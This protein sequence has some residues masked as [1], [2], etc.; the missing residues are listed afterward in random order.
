MTSSGRYPNQRIPISIRG[1]SYPS[2]RAA[3]RA[4][5]VRNTTIMRALNRGTHE[6]SAVFTKNAG[7]LEGVWYYCRADAAAALGVNTSTFCKQIRKGKIAW[8]PEISQ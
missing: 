7:T 1:V 2:I 3:A 6:T 5:G 8:K 4:L